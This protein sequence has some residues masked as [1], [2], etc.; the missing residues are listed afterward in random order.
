MEQCLR[1][2]F[3]ILKPNAWLHQ[4]QVSHTI[5]DIDIS[6]HASNHDSPTPSLVTLGMI[7]ANRG[8]LHRAANLYQKAITT[9]KNSYFS[10]LAHIEL[11]NIMYEWNELA[12]SK[13][14]LEMG[15]QPK[16]PIEDKDI[17]SRACCL[18]ARHI[19]IH[20]GC[21]KSIS[22]L[23][24]AHNILK[25]NAIS[26]FSLAQLAATAIRTACRQKD[27][28]T[29]ARWAQRLPSQTYDIHINLLNGI[30][31]CYLM[32]GHNEPLSALRHLNSLSHASQKSGLTHYLVETRCLQALSATQTARSLTYL[33]EAL[34]IAAAEGYIRTFVDM[35]K[36]MIRLLQKITTPQLQ[37]YVIKLLNATE[38]AIT[39][40]REIHHPDSPIE[41]P[42]RVTLSHRELEVLQ[43]MAKG[44][45]N[46]HISETL[47][48][49]LGTVKTHVHN[50]LYKLKAKNRINAILQYRQ[51]DEPKT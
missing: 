35:G 12:A 40:T 47:H 43:L 34:S 46:Q 49:S 3:G 11:A 20:G 19:S 28:Y 48:I 9:G 39:H 14:H 38:P 44:F 30:S 8:K 31:H 45:T 32:L 18:L 10:K 26:Q 41:Q 4:K 33:K 17:Q 13:R 6:Q 7:Q 51:L 25:V 5:S 16:R 29:A 42:M 50:I 36:P 23:V 1:H 22:L 24:E 37:P 21:A 15:L 2:H 27:L